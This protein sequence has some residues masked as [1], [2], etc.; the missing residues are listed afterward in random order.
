[1]LGSTGKLLE[2]CNFRLGVNC[3]TMGK[4]YEV[5]RSFP[6]RAFSRDNLSNRSQSSSWGVKTLSISM[7]TLSYFTLMGYHHCPYLIG[8]LFSCKFL[9]LRRNGLGR[10]IV[11]GI[12]VVTKITSRGDKHKANPRVG[13]CSF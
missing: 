2:W 8:I 6:H 11:G 1:M 7:A 10:L 12:L 13:C 3:R 5:E 4:Q 9:T